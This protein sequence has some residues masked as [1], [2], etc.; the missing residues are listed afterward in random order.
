LTPKEFISNK[1]KEISEKG[2]KIFPENFIFP[3]ETNEISLPPET[4]VLGNEFFG[5]YEVLTV[6]G[7]SFC[8]TDTLYKAKYYVYAGR[9]K[10][11]VFNIPLNEK[12]IEKV[13][14]S[15]EQYLDGLLKH[16]ESE[17]NSIFPE[18]KDVSNIVSEVFRILNLNRL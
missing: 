14:R 9:Q 18:N 1:T 6:A 17:Y 11:R 3:C 5:S 13:V 7:D 4:L 2:I 8:H 10:S 12:D 15:Y 16:I